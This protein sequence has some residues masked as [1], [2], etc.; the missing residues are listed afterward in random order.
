MPDADVTQLYVVRVDGAARLS[1]LRS[2][3][4]HDA[5]ELA[6]G[7][8]LVRSTDTQ[9]RLY[10]DLKRLVQPESLFVG[11]LDERPK[12]KGV[13]AGSLKWLRDG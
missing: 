4:T 3:R 10:H 12:F 13:A 9:S 7:F 5:M 2:S 8:F 11:K 1:K 6:E